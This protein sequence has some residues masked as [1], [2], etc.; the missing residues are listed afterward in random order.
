[1]WGASIEY[2]PG[3]SGRPKASSTETRV[4][5]R[6]SPLRSRLGSMLAPVAIALALVWPALPADGQPRRG[7]QRPPDVHRALEATARAID[8]AESVVRGPSPAERELDAA[9]ELQG[10]AH[11]ALRSRMPEEAM[12]LTRDARRHAE[13]ARALARGLPEPSRVD[14]QLQRTRELLDRAAD[15]M[16]GCKDARAHQ[17]LREAF[18][19]HRR[20]E[21]AARSGRHLAALRLTVSARELGGEALDAC[22]IGDQGRD[23]AEASARALERTDEVI[24]R[25]SAALAENAPARAKRELA[26]AIEMQADARR[27]RAEGEFEACLQL[28]L[29]ARARAE[30]VVRRGP[31]PPGAD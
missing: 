14:V 29:A 24:A 31:P 21:D 3:R 27:D 20:A 18:D 19:T 12:R 22:A 23:L 8:D 4:V 6:Y 9:R 17:R 25:V 1:M 10:R 2:R 28:T 5:L 26:R 15:R 13:R 11:R 16:A 30:R 7:P